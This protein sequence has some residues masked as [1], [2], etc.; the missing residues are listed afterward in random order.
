MLLTPSKRRSLCSRA[1]SFNALVASILFAL[2][3]LLG[4]FPQ[5][6]GAALPLVRL[7]GHVP[8]AVLSANL[9]GDVPAGQTISMAFVLP[10]TNQTELND[11]LKRLYDPTDPL[12]GH[13]LT[14]AQF[15]VQFGPTDSDVSA[16]A[17]YAQSQGFTVT[18]VSSNRTIIDVVA[19]AYRV[20]Q[21]FS[22]HLRSYV[23]SDGRPFYA[24]DDNPAVPLD[25][26]S[27]LVGIIGLDNS[28]VL[29]PARSHDGVL[30]PTPCGSADRQRPRQ[31]GR[32]PLAI[33]RRRTT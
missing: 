22:L 18:G 16:V 12:Y 8:A 23:H 7:L 10:L 21:S 24:P 28:A 9:V 11:L 2:A 15:A 27:K 33:S 1:C 29:R 31:L 25:I 6:A 20:E 17:R 30:Y 32:S 4:L 14:P 5:S 19:P 13:Y 3:S 26:A